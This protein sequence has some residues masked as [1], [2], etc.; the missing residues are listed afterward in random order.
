[1][2]WRCLFAVISNTALLLGSL[3][4]P[5]AH[6][7]RVGICSRGEVFRRRLGSRS[8]LEKRLGER[9]RLLLPDD[10]SG[11]SPLY[12]TVAQRRGHNVLLA[13]VGAEA[14]LLAAAEHPDVILLDVTM[15][16]LDGRDVL[17]QLKANPK[18]V[19]VIVAS[20][21]ATDQNLC[22]QLV[23]PGADHVIENPVDLAIAMSQPERLAERGRKG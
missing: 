20:A 11:V 2:K 7:A 8:A 18:E 13:R 12:R 10:D 16:K 14:L 15:P 22:A 4:A 17:A 21:M 6:Q 19:L 23:D 3:D 5:A 9:Y 1:M